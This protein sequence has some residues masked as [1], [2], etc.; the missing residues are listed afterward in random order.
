[1]EAQKMVRVDIN[2]KILTIDLCINVLL[3]SPYYFKE[4]DFH[5]ILKFDKTIVFSVG[6]Y[7]NQHYCCP[8]LL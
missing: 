6:R 8:L 3:G 2:N 4:A 1:M 5:I 7:I